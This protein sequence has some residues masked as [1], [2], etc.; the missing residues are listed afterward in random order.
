MAPRRTRRS[1]GAALVDLAAGRELAVLGNGPWAPRWYWRD[2]LEAMQEASRGAGH[3]DDHPAAVLRGYAPTG[4]WRD[5]PDGM[6]SGRVWRYRAAA[7][8]REQGQ[9]QRRSV[10]VA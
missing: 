2:D 10:E 9:Q 3:G 1:G 8:Q 7:G 4:E 6:G 5:H